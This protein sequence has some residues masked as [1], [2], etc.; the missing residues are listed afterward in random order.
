MEV[1]WRGVA[2][3][4]KLF[5]KEAGLVSRKWY[6]DL[7]NYQRNGYDLDARYEEGLASYREK[8]I[9]DVLLQ[10]GPTLSKNLERLVSA[11]M[12]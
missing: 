12:A 9:I 1:A 11:A 5:A 7:A 6:P 2:A 10:E 3:Y 8:C 4:G